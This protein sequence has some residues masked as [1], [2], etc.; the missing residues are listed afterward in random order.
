M[1]KAFAFRRIGKDVAEVLATSPSQS[2]A[3][4]RLGVDRSTLH[5]WLAA[6]KVQRPPGRE[7]R[8]EEAT[9]AA[10]T[11]DQTPEQWAASVRTDY[12]FSSTEEVLVDLGAVTLRLSKDERLSPSERLAA[13]GRFQTLIKQLHLEAAEDG[14]ETKTRGDIRPWP[15]R[16]S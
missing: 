5:R 8:A 4:R 14:E 10:A 7:K 9:P 15:R 6:G 16:A 2:A 1:G 3:A 12:E 11:T 13:V